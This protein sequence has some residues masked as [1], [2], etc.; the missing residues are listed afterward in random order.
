M[1]QKELSEKTGILQGD[2]SKILK[3]IDTLA[4]V[5]RRVMKVLNALEWEVKII[6]GEKM[7][8]EQCEILADVLSSKIKEAERLDT[9]FNVSNMRY[10]ELKKEL[11]VEQEHNAIVLEAIKQKKEVRNV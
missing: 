3:S 5:P 2:V 9:L 11:K 1:K 8:C 6:K 7:T 10:V 4:F